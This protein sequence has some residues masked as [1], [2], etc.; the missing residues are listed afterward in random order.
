MHMFLRIAPFLL[1]PAL[2]AGATAQKH[3]WYDDQ[4]TLRWF[5]SFDAAKQA[6]RAAN[7]AILVEVGAKT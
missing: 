5:T 1:L 4:S 3:P 6:A 7:K 2:T